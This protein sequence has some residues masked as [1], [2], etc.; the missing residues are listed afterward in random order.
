MTRFRPWIWI[1]IIVFI[2]AVGLILLSNAQRNSPTTVFEPFATPFG[3]LP[4]ITPSAPLPWETPRP[5][6]D[7]IEYCVLHSEPQIVG[8]QLGYRYPNPKNPNWKTTC[9]EQ[10][11]VS[12]VD[13]KPLTRQANITNTVDQVLPG[14]YDPSLCTQ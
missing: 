11:F 7:M 14:L 5:Q 3:V 9:C 12:I 2:L 6:T 10:G 4:S 13:G 8:L 1:I